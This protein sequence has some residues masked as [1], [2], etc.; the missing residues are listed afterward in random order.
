MSLFRAIEGFCLPWHPQ[1]GRI[2]FALCD[3]IMAAPYV[4]DRPAIIRLPIVLEQT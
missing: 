2:C 4:S 1:G 3:P